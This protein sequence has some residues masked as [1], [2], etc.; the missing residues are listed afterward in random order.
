VLSSGGCL[1]VKASGRAL[2]AQSSVF[3]R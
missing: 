1:Y 3:R 2:T